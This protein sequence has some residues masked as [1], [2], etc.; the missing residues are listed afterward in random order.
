MGTLSLCF[1]LSLATSHH[2]ALVQWDPHL[3]ASHQWQ[4][5][6]NQFP[7]KASDFCL[8]KIVISCLKMAAP[9]TLCWSAEVKDQFPTKIF[10]EILKG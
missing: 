8:L 3:R 2:P 5:H 4:A 7:E 1:V 6:R 10:Q 9:A